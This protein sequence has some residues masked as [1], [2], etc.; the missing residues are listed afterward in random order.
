[1]NQ[2]LGTVV[3]AVGIAL[4]LVGG[5]LLLLDGSW[6]SAASALLS[7]AV[8]LLLLRQIRRPGWAPPRP[9]P[10]WRLVAFWVLVLVMS[11]LFAAAAI[12]TPH[13]GRRWIAV[14][15][16]VVMLAVGAAVT[17][18]FRRVNSSAGRSA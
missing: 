8:A 18:A 12:A 6:L 5:V 15:L 17:V 7:A 10:R 11:A 16:V 14:A 13:S 2:R 9:L 4:S 1:M 3:L